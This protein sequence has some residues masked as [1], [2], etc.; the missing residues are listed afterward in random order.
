[1]IKDTSLL[2]AESRKLLRKRL[3]R[4]V[5]SAY[6]VAQFILQVHLIT[7]LPIE[8]ISILACYA[9]IGDQPLQILPSK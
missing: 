1:M 5:Y 8:L 6:V 7:S 3:A 2:E 9:S 4:I